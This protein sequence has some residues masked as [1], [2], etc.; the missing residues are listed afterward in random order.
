MSNLNLYITNYYSSLFSDL[1]EGNFS[2]DE[3]RTDDISQVFVE[4]NNLL[5]SPYTEDE[6]KK[7]IFQMEHNE[8]PGLGGIL[9]NLP[10]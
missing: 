10:Y 3:S 6:I 5:T 9:F 2:M 1:E 7:A 8:A 4:E